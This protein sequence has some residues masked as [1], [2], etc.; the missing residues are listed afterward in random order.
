MKIQKA[1]ILKKMPRVK[2]GE[3]GRDTSVEKVQQI[4]QGAMQE[5]LRHGYAGT[6]MD[7]VAACAG[8]S[9]ATVYSHFR[10][11]E[12]L[13]KAL[14]EKLARQKFQ[15][16]FG[17]ETLEGEPEVVLRELTTKALNVMISDEGHRS[18]MR[19]L[20]GESGRFPELA[21]FWV[22]CAMKPT[23]DALSKYLASR[24][25]L[26]ISDP[27][28]TARVCVGSVVHYVIIQETLHGK[29][30]LPMESDRLVDCLTNLIMNNKNASH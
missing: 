9:K 18:F 6:S 16:I 2:M 14:V 10:D 28:A 13:F 27:E 7:K 17:E 5:F 23:I 15:L 19:M 3:L 12:G 1:G 26:N 30:I 25:E 8:V 4:L 20:V 11:K 24:P 29:D 21:K 22:S